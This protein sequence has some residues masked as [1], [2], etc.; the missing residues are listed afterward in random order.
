MRR[1]HGIGSCLLLVAGL[2]LPAVAQNASV[3][4][5]QVLGSKGAVEIEIE[6]SDR[7]VPQAQVLTGPDRLVLDFPNAMPSAELR[8]QSVN[9]GEVKDVRVALFQSNP[10]V[11]RVVFDLKS[12]QSYQI[13]PNGRSVMI[14]VTGIVQEAEGIEEFPPET[15]PGLVNTSFPAT[16]F[17]ATSVSTRPV[18]LQVGPA[19]RASLDVSFRDGLLSIRA[20]KASLSDVLFAVHQRTGA[21]IALIAGAEQEPVAADLGPGPAPEVLARLLNGS[22]FNFLILSSASDPRTL[23]RVIL[24]QRGEGGV[25]AM[26]PVQSASEDADDDS[27]PQPVAGGRVVPPQPPAAA[28]EVPPGRELPPRGQPEERAAEENTPD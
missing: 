25:T 1:P 4:R 5:V 11:T 2:L 20:N 13:F 26:P 6:A 21:E 17:P 22:R 3:R 28:A 18:A 9:R 8:S 10:P 15:R 24:S 23:D 19:T 7:L 12:P 27:P 16:S 14:K